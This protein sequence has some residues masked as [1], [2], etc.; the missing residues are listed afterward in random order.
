MILKKLIMKNIRSYSKLELEFPE[1]SILLAGDIGSGKTSILLALQFALFGLQPGQKGSSLI[2]VGETEAYVS[3]E[4]EINEELVIIERTIKKAKNGSISQGSN[5]ITISGKREE[6]ST[7][8]A[9]NKII[10]MLNYPKEFVKKSNLLYKYTVY[11]P[12]ESMKEIIQESP[13]IRLDTLRHIF[14]IDRYKRI[15]ENSE[16]FIQKI[17]ESVKLKEVEIREI[18]LIK[19]KLNNEDEKKI[20]LAR[21]INNLN[22]E[23]NLISNSKKE[24]EQKIKE[25]ERLILEKNK[26]NSELIRRDTELKGKKELKLK[27]E[28]EVDLMCLQLRDKIEFSVE[29]LQETSNLVIEHKNRLDNLNIQF[30]KINSDISVLLS[31]KEKAI[32]LKEKV[33]HLENCPT[34]YQSVESGHKEK[35]SKRTQYEIEDIN[36][37]LEPKIIDKTRLIKDIENE[38]EFI[39]GYEQD[40]QELEKDK[41]K[42]QH[43]RDIELKIKSDTMTLEKINF[44]MGALN[45]Q[46]NEAKISLEAY[47]DFE[48]QYELLKSNFDNLSKKTRALEIELAQKN[49][50]AELI[51]IKIEELEKEISYK[52]RIKEQVNYLRQL[53]DW[54][55]EKFLSL[56]TMA[57]TNVLA[58]LRAD[59][60][61]LFN[62]WFSIL[63]S[64]SLSVRLN[65]DFTP[66]IENQDYEIDY[67]FLS[68]GERTAVALAYRL[69]LNQILNSLLSKIK[70][71][72]LI[73]LDEPTDGFSEQQLDKMRDIFD[74]LNS[75]QIILVS[76]E[77][78]I[79]GFVDNVIRI[80][81]EG[82]SSIEKSK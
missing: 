38:K 62:E 19:E 51:K 67:E 12:Q 48:K 7:S 1:G 76:H 17:K 35:I 79:E 70:T 44:E 46:I 59:F 74:Q 54:I 68:G 14:G 16:V 47:K 37:E 56:I 69:A 6:L 75:R 22:I 57:E 71:K 11:T 61:K 10:E 78:K 18:N 65:E 64:Q 21:E 80:K 72:D 45:S 41:I 52:E 27:I 39:K 24:G 34:C 81:K 73:I 50:E 42:Y 25:S 4:L 28:K 30:I 13:E 33:L 31:K 2:R 36:R 5:N 20:K 55:E 43:Q 40:K 58:K 66:I 49:K 77:Q 82:A 26:I 29:K 9:K 3:L 8:E 32:E 63:V 53:Q 15:K 23:Y 60:S